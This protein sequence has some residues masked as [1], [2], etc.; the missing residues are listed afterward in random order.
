MD[1]GEENE[2]AF[3]GWLKW[4]FDELVYEKLGVQFRNKTI[5]MRGMQWVNYDIDLDV[6]SVDGAIIV[7]VYTPLRNRNSISRPPDRN[8]YSRT[9]FSVGD[10][11]WDEV[12]HLL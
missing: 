3:D 12:A 11:M 6:E 4:V 10:G 1:G 8:T 5:I 9:N 2:E 7:C